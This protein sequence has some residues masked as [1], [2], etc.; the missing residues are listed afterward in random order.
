MT[1]G[2]VQHI[3]VEESTSI[4]WVKH[5]MIFIIL[6]CSGLLQS[7]KI[8][9]KLFVF[10]GQGNICEFCNWGNWAWV[11]FRKNAYSAVGEKIY[12]QEKELLYRSIYFPPKWTYS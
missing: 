11:V 5:I 4:Q 3:T 10:L 12:S 8:F 2:L 7:G 6:P 9:G 1:N